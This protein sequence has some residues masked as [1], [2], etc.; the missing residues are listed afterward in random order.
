M[1]DFRL[2]LIDSGLSD[3]GCKGDKF[4]WFNNREGSHFT[5]ERLDR[6]CANVKWLEMFCRANVTTEVASSSDHRS[7]LVSIALGGQ[8]FVRGERPFRYEACWAQRK[9][10]HQVVE[11]AWKRPWL[12]NNKLEMATKGLKRF[13]E[14]LRS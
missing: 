11:E 9:D 7:I 12:V 10:C 3:M 13:K 5:K 8:E 2:A 1:E 14:K 6:A 4:M